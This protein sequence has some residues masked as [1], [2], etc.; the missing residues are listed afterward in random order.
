[1]EVSGLARTCRM[2]DFISDPTRDAEWRVTSVS[3]E[4]ISEPPHGVG[5]TYKSVDKF[6]GRRIEAGQE[7]T[8]WD[9]PNQYG[10]KGDSGPMSFELIWNF[11]A[12][13][14]GTK[15]TISVEAQSGGFFRMA[16]NLF[17]SRCKSS[18]TLIWLI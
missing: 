9:S 7:I 16:E 14:N 11:E 17:G 4:W 1:M 3:A 13:D 2:F 6:M 5:S 10:F 15:A 8:A 18:L 12:Q